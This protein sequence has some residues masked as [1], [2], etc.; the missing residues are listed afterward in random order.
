MLPSNITVFGDIMDPRDIAD[1]EIKATNYLEEGEGVA[2]YSITLLSEALLG[3][4][5]LGVGAYAHSEANGIISLWFNIDELMQ[6][7]ASFYGGGVTLPL[8]VEITTDSVPPRRRQ[9]TFG[10][11]VQQQ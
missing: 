5:E 11:K 10:V 9:R 4:L 7:D 8:E 1:Y 3:G 2:S 6:S